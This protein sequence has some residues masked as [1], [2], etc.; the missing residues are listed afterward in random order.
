[1]KLINYHTK[2]HSAQHHKEMRG[3]VLQ[4]ANILK[5]L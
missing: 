2:H 5:V 3:F 1:M 4:Q